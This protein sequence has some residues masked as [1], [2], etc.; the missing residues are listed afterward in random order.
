MFSNGKVGETVG[1]E[2]SS[3]RLSFKPIRSPTMAGALFSIDKKFFDRLGT[4]DSGFDIW[5]GENLELAFKT[6]MCGGS[7]EII[8]CSLVGHIFRKRS[9]YKWKTGVNVLRKNSVRLAEVWLDEYKKYY[10]DRI[11]ND[12]GEFGDVTSRLELRKKLQCK[13]FD[14]YLKTVYPELYIPGEALGQGEIRNLGDGGD[15][16]LDSA[17]KRDDFH[18]PI[19]LWPCHSQVKKA[20]SRDEA[21]IDYTGG[22]VIIYPCHGAGGNQ[23]WIYDPNPYKHFKEILCFSIAAHLGRP[24]EDYFLHQPK[25]KVTRAR[26]REGLIRAHLMG[27]E[28]AKAP[29]LTY[30]DSHCWL[31]PLLQRIANNWTMVVCPVIDVI[32]DETFEYHFRES[33]EVKVGGF[34]WNLQFSWHV[35][36]EIERKS[37]TIAGGLFSIDKKFFERLGT[38]DSG[39]DILGGENLELSFKGEFGDVT[40][41]LELRKKLQCKSLDWYLKTVYPELYIPG[42]ALGLGE[43]WMF[44]NEGEIK[45]DEACLDYS[46]GDVI[47]YP[48]HGAGGN[49]MWIYDPNLHTIQ[50]TSSRKCMELAPDKQSVLMALCSGSPR[51]KWLVQNYEP[52][53]LAKSAS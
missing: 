17:A 50:Q 33:G 43:Y 46:G 31:E 10:Y 41:R 34:D 5:G 49:Q 26:R 6:W 52:T 14:W 45:R 23:M 8:P 4:Y 7:L 44:S 48:C 42:E 36:P 38:Y 21:C 35:M 22:D 25:V 3:P 27:A 2:S 20:K 29:I 37:P 24:L 19:G 18:K 51:Q 13:S 40:S 9:P 32:D 47:L 30:L 15:T 1:V 28:A 53:E 11:G 39:F 12:L 16:C